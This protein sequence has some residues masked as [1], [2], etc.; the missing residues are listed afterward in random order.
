LGSRDDRIGRG[1]HARPG[2][3]LM[4]DTVREIHTPEGV[5]LRLPAAGPVPRACAWLIDLGIRLGLVLLASM[6]LALLGRFGTGVYLVFVFVVIWAY[7]V[8]FEALWD[9]QTPGKR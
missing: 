8:A 6:F 2:G 4:L 7:P 9:G 1:G 3:G 5:A